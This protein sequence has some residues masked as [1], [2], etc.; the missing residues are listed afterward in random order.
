MTTDQV[1]SAMSDEYNRQLFG[2]LMVYLRSYADENGGMIPPWM[3]D[4]VFKMVP[5][6]AHEICLEKWI[7]GTRHYL[8]VQRGEDDA[9][10]AG[11]WHFPGTMYRVGDVHDMMRL[12]QRM[13]DEIG[14]DAA[15]LEG[16][17]RS[18]VLVTPFANARQ[19][20]VSTAYL[21][22]VP[23]DWECEHGTWLTAWDIEDLGAAVLAE[24]KGIHADLILHR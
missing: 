22:K 4:E 7:D 11:I 8:L 13:A 6:A 20:A 5:G 14:C 2:Q 1:G 23:D 21:V 3:F 15:E 18:R 16:F 19:E 24:H 9:Y 12:W 10:F 17:P